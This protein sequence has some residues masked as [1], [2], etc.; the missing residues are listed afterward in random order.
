VWDMSHPQS[1]GFPQIKPH[2][3]YNKLGLSWV[4]GC[5]LLSWGLSKGL[6]SESFSR[7]GICVGGHVWCMCGMACVV[8]VCQ[9]RCEICMAGQV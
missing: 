5:P 3:V 8:Y 1:S 9:G 6:L 4:L 7:C 2:V